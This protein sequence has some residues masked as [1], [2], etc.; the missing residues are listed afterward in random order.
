[1][2]RPTRRFDKKQGDMAASPSLTI[3]IRYPLELLGTR[4]GRMDYPDEKRAVAPISPS[5]HPRGG[6]L[7]IKQALKQ[8]VVPENQTQQNEVNQGEFDCNF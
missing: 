4:T 8:S 7:W 5:N 6:R 2:Q 1:M 3:P